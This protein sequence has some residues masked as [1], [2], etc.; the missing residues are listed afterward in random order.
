MKGMGKENKYNKKSKKKKEKDRKEAEEE[1]RIGNKFIRGIEED[2]KNNGEPKKE[3]AGRNEDEEYMD[4]R[5][6]RIK[7]RKKNR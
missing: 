2:E 5:T 7:G 1:K 6:Q 3:G 4:K